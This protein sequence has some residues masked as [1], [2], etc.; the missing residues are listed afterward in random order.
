MPIRAPTQGVFGELNWHPFWVRPGWQA[1]KYWT[2]ATKMQDDCIVKEALR[3]QWDLVELGREIRECWLSCLKM[4][5]MTTFAGRNCGGKWSR[6][7]RDGR[8][9]ECKNYRAEVNPMTNKLQIREV[10]W[11]DESHETFKVSSVGR[12]FY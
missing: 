1:A 11:E 8:N 12:W 10:R 5:L 3:C 2:R 7:M 6:A 4:S 9:I